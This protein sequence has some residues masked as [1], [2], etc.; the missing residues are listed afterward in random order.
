MNPQS[1]P[2]YLTNQVS[3]WTRGV[4]DQPLS[5]RNRR[6][7]QVEI[8]FPLLPSSL[9]RY[10]SRFHLRTWICFSSPI[11]LH[12]STMHL[13]LADPLECNSKTI[14]T[15]NNDLFPLFSKHPPLLPVAP[16][17]I[18]LAFTSNRKSMTIIT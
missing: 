2:Y 10:R 6:T 18:F 17:K 15:E 8:P 7:S 4:E 5:V 11:V 1:L 16:G 13:K 3:E 9:V 14:G 12:Y